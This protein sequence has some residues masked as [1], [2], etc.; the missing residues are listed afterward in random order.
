MKQKNHVSTAQTD[1]PFTNPYKMKII[2]IGGE[3]GE[4]MRGRWRKQIRSKTDS[5]SSKSITRAKFCTDNT[6]IFTFPI[7]KCKTS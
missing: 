1:F 6:I 4:G 3:K 5:T 2:L 7:T